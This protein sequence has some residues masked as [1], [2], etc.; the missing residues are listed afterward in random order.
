[1]I[2]TKKLRSTIK[3]DKTVRTSFHHL[4]NTK[5]RQAYTTNR[6]PSICT[7][8][9]GIIC[10]YSSNT[11]WK[12]IY[13]NRKR[14]GPRMEPCGTEAL[15]ARSRYDFPSRNARNSIRLTFLKKTSMMKPVK[16]LWYIKIPMLKVLAILLRLSENAI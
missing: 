14:V 13:E 3:T 4:P 16:T 15:L 11:D 7:V 2:L 6:R 1:M 9:S 8:E 12:I 5:L 10:I